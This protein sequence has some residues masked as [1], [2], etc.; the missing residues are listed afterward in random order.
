MTTLLIFLIAAFAP[1]AVW[2]Y[3]MVAF[4]VVVYIAGFFYAP[5]K[6]WVAACM[7]IPLRLTVE[8]LT[9]EPGAES[10]P[11]VNL[12][13]ILA[14]AAECAL[15][16]ALMGVTAFGLVR[17]RAIGTSTYDYCKNL[18]RGRS[19]RKEDYSE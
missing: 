18:V 17:G 7:L 3:A 1:P 2:L 10:M 19:N 14:S 16:L 13:P 8:F 12:M 11:L 6:L 15:F 9:G 4:A 5:N